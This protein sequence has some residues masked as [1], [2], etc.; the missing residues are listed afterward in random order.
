MTH[1]DWRESLRRDKTGDRTE[2]IRARDAAQDCWEAGGV[3]YDKLR[4]ELAQ[5]DLIAGH[6]IRDVVYEILLKHQDLRVLSRPQGAMRDWCT[7][8]GKRCV[9]LTS[10]QR[11]LV[12][13]ARADLGI[14]RAPVRHGVWSRLRL[15]RSRMT[16]AIGWPGGEAPR[17]P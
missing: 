12:V 10:L 15:L 13:L 8:S 1:L 11:R 7:K 14:D 6:P 16:K 3:L 2:D 17:Q 5:L 9:E 4:F